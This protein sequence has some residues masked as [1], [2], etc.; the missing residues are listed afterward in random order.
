M[1]VCARALAT[2]K[3]STCECPAV[4]KIDK[5]FKGPLSKRP[6][7]SHTL[8]GVVTGSCMLQVRSSKQD[9]IHNSIVSTLLALMDGIDSRGQIV[10]IGATNRIDALDAALRRPGRW[11]PP[12]PSLPPSSI[13]HL[14][15][16]SPVGLF[17]HAVTERK[18]AF[19]VDMFASLCRLGE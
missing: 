7:L 16:A 5:V 10:L 15:V 2:T 9:Q 19:Y 18:V 13:Q 3:R 8:P 14:I 11:T 17:T 4:W 1:T 6:S 12:P